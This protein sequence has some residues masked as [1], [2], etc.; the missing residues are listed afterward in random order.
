MARRPRLFVA[1]LPYHIVQRGNNRSPIFFSNED[2]RF[3]L[4]VLQEAKAKYPCFVYSYCLMINHFHLLLEPREK[5][6]V[7]LLMKLLGAKYVRYVNKARKRTGTLWES[8]FKCS[9]ID[10]EPYFLACLRY[11]EMNPVRAGIT[12]SPELYRWSSYRVRAYGE[13][14]PFLDLDP[15]YNSLGVNAPERQLH[16]R[17]FFHHASDDSEPTYKLIREMTNKGGIIGSID[18]KEQMEEILHREIIIR[19]PGRPRKSE[20]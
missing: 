20:K 11:V 1:G 10:S 17:Q 12:D 9:L 6:N 5:D 19:P 3:F 18:F 16:Y 8:R 14:S 4:E 7:S 2:Y 15:W 13:K